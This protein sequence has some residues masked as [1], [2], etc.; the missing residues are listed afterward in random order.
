MSRKYQDPRNWPITFFCPKCGAVLNTQKGFNPM[1][2]IWICTE[3]GQFIEDS[4][5]CNDIVYERWNDCE[6]HSN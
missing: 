1:D 3:C 2:R 5:L 6:V 4:S